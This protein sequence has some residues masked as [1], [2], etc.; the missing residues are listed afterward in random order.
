M[1]ETPFLERLPQAFVEAHCV[2]LAAWW[3]TRERRPLAVKL[4]WPAL[5]FPEFTHAT[6]EMIVDK[7]DG[8]NRY[9]VRPMTAEDDR[10]IGRVAMAWQGVDP[11]KMSAAE[12]FPIYETPV[13]AGPIEFLS[14][15]DPAPM[16]KIFEQVDEV[17]RQIYEAFKL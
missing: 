14:P 11:R 12:L 7:V 6:V 3:G 10:I 15:P 16:A 17:Q 1:N 13:E 4:M 5:M 9:C 2:Q 8:E